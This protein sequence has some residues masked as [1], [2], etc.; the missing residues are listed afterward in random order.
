MQGYLILSYL[1]IYPMEL[2]MAERKIKYFSMVVREG[3][4][5]KDLA[6]KVY[7]SDV[8]EKCVTWK[9]MNYEHINDMKGALKTLHIAE[10]EANKEFHIQKSW[11]KK[12][13]F[14]KKG[15]AYENW[16]LQR[17]VIRERRHALE[18]ERQRNKGKKG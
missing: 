6:S 12:L 9:D 17:E 1:R 8:K 5:H 16:K 3:I 15:I 10:E 11:N 2:T 4:K 13:R 18:N 7:W 14:H